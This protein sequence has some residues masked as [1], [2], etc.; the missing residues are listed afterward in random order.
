[1]AHDTDP[2]YDERTSRMPAED[3]SIP[4]QQHAVAV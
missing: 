4:A 3:Q 1:M 2:R